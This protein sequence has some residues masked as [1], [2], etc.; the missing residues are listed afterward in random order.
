MS[1]KGPEIKETLSAWTEKEP[2]QTVHQSISI[3]IKVP[4]GTFQ[5]CDID[6]TIFQLEYPSMTKC[7]FSYIKNTWQ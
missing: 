5:Q 4:C 6:T 7:H 3:D 2:D 1:L